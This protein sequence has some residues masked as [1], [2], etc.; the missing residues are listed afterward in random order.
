MTTKPEPHMQRRSLT[1]AAVAWVRLAAHPATV[2]RAF[3]T[4]IIVSLVLIAIN[5]GSA[6][7]SG[8]L[9]RARCIQIC[10]TVLVPYIVSTVSSVATRRELA[11]KHGPDKQSP[12]SSLRP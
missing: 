3:I 11:A 2:R 1:S 4:A 7:M 6:V 5:H 10:L 9:T 8:Q 12:R